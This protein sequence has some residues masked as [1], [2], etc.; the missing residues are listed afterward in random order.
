ME[1][2]IRFLL[3]LFLISCSFGS[4]RE[5]FEEKLLDMLVIGNMVKILHL[6]GHLGEF[7]SRSPQK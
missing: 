2:A 3:G 5:I 7:A 6:L 4:F 1:K